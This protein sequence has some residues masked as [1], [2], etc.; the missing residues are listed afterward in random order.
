MFLKYET[1]LQSNNG[2]ILCRLTTTSQDETSREPVGSPTNATK[3][4]L[5]LL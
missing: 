4:E 1:H 5:E 2:L 3:G